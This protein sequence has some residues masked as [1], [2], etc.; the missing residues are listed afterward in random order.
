MDN[1]K[2]REL[3]HLFRKKL[4]DPVDQI[5]Y[6]EEDWDA[7][8]QMLDKQKR[9]KGIIYLLPILS[10]VA[11]LLLL[12]FGW[13]MLQ[14][15][16]TQNNAA[17][18]LQASIIHPKT[19]DS[20]KSE[21]IQT[22][23]QKEAIPTKPN[24]TYIAKLAKPAVV[25]H[26]PV[27]I[28][29]GKQISTSTQTTTAT[30]T[31]P[32][33]I[34]S[35]TDTLF[36]QQVRKDLIAGTKQSVKDNKPAAPAFNPDNIQKNIQ[37]ELTSSGAGIIVNQHTLTAPQVVNTQK[38]SLVNPIGPSVSLNNI[39]AN[40]AHT[41]VLQQQGTTTVADQT[42]RPATGIKS[43]IVGNNPPPLTSAEKM[44]M[45]LEKTSFA[46][47]N[48][49]KTANKT[50]TFKSRYSVGVVGG[51]DV[52]GVGSF[53]QAKLGTKA[54]VM[55]N[56]AVIGKFTVSTGSV[57]SETPYAASYA[58]YHFPYDFKTDPQNISANCTMLDIP[59]NVGY[60]V[61][62]NEHNSISI[63]TGLSSYIMLQ[64]NF[65]FNYA[66]APTTS[67]SMPNNESYL[68]KIVNFNATY[69]RQISSKAGIM[70][71]PYL[72]LPLADVGYSQVKLQTT[73]LALGLTWNLN[74]PP[75]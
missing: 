27:I 19:I 49:N 65:T 55:F 31:K 18:K 17:S 44:Q 36:S 6:E 69:E 53:Q 73:G 58:N 7:L 42:N 61:F 70:V 3:D 71:Q 28:N 12:F 9:R 34:Q 26:N 67:Y 54:G 22:P 32:A 24:T 48:N 72:K 14:P 35:G 39:A 37:N 30:I 21:K 11:A 43:A 4:E 57:Y 15:K 59:L 41:P 66:N 33:S 29:A 60:Q 10:G 75:K 20:T 25:N 8:E 64:Q 68:F 13:W 45:L 23:V 16:T 52:N 74:T 1:E 62:N 5:R 50:P 47:N 63:G 38:P 51:Q 40:T 56:A 2:D 46:G